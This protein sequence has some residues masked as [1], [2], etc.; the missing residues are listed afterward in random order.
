M[1][2][3]VT[4]L[5]LDTDFPRAPG[6]VGCAETYLGDIEILRIA[7]A[8]VGQI[9]CADPAA[10]AIA[11]FEAALAQAR[12]DIVVTSCGFLSYW[13]THL[14]RQ[15][16]KAFIGSALTALPDLCERYD[17]HDILTVTFD[18][19]SLNESH[20]GPYRTDVI[21]LPRDMHLRQVISQNLTTLDVERAAQD[22][23]DF[24]TSQCKSHHK[25]IL[26]E[27]TNL[28]PYKHAL[29][30]RTGLPITDIL[31]CIEAVRP[32]TIQPAFLP[33]ALSLQ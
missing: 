12:G 3:C 25:H 13:Q 29:S 11:P 24:V 28:P 26:L 7:N 5:Q 2:P 8:T 18:A 22:I 4:V 30:A 10:I 31:T 17:P 1:A 23:T 21:G 19:S 33:S 9:V 14:E 20:F 27:C 16:D 6:D 15:T 32:N